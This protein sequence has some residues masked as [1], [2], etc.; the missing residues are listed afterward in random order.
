MK[1][2]ALIAAVALVHVA[3]ATVAMLPEDLPLTNQKGECLS[4]LPLDGKFKSCSLN[5]DAWRVGARVLGDFLSDSDITFT[6]DFA[7]PSPFEDIS[8]S[9]TTHTCAAHIPGGGVVY[10]HLKFPL[11]AHYSMSACAKVHGSTPCRVEMRDWHNRVVDYLE[12]A[13]PANRSCTVDS[14]GSKSECVAWDASSSETVSRMVIRYQGLVPATVAVRQL[15]SINDNTNDLVFNLQPGEEFTISPSDLSLSSTSLPDRLALIMGETATIIDILQ[16]TGASA[17]LPGMYVGDEHQYLIA[18]SWT[19][20]D[21]FIC[22][23]SEAA[24]VLQCPCEDTDVQEMCLTSLKGFVIRPSEEY[25]I[26]LVTDECS[27]EF[28]SVCLHQVGNEEGYFGVPWI[29]NRN[30]TV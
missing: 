1:F 28:D 29:L 12:F 3:F 21:Q 23:V 6:N 18:K 8:S 7:S 13:A 2:V 24:D 26:G 4:G 27:C 11:Y 17:A 25:Y 5:K 22:P 10:Q 19:S 30:S 15:S 20:K 9:D 14:T 16:L